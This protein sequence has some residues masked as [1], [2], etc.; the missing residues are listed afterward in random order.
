MYYFVN[1]TAVPL[2]HFVSP[3]R[4]D[5][6]FNFFWCDNNPEQTLRQRERERAS[7]RCTSLSSDE[8]EDDLVLS[9]LL[10]L[11]DDD[12]SSLSVQFLLVHRRPLEDLLDDLH[13]SLDDLLELGRATRVV[14]VNVVGRKQSR[15]LAES[16]HS[17]DDLSRGTFLLEFGSSEDV[18]EDDDIV[19]RVRLVVRSSFDLGGELD[20]TRSREVTLGELDAV[21]SDLARLEVRLDVVRGDVRESLLD[22]REVLAEFASEHRVVGV[23]TELDTAAS[24]VRGEDNGADVELLL[25]VREERLDVVEVL[26]R[27]VED[28]QF[29]KRGLRQDFH[30]LNG[31]S[32]STSVTHLEG[33]NHALSDRASEF[34]D[35][36]KTRD[37]TLDGR[38]EVFLTSLRERKEVERADIVSNAE[39]RDV[40]GEERSETLV[41]VLGE[42]GGEGGESSNEGE[43]GFEEGVESVGRVLETV[44]ALESSS[45]ESNVP[46]REL[47]NEVEHLSDDS[48]ESVSWSA[49][50][51][52][53]RKQART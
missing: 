22:A 40:G 7:T 23:G 43:E 19:V 28:N 52:S 53:D 46:V 36:L 33:H 24:L 3:C 14:D 18:E 12:L 31:D 35:S 37:L 26:L 13:P 47:V 29:G 42:E 4:A 2:L 49:D 27:R 39:S 32:D 50:E 25:D 17:V 10:L 6:I 8:G 5:E 44:L 30:E 15:L 51:M 21:D 34:D 45:V 20:E 16:L 41:D 11:L 48:V 1:G 9:D 38:V